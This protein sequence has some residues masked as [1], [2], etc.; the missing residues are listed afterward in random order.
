MLSGGGT[1]SSLMLL[2]A[3]FLILPRVYP[4]PP[5]PLRCLSEDYKSGGGR[6]LVEWDPILPC[7]A[8]CLIPNSTSC[9]PHP[10]PPLD[11][12]QKIISQE[13]VGPC[14]VGPY[15]PLCCSLLNST[16]SSLCCSCLP[17]VYPPPPLRCLSED[18]TCKSGGGRG[19]VEWDLILPS[20]A[21]CFIP[22]P[23]SC[24]TPLPPPPNF[25][26]PFRRL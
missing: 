4:T 1:L 26:M 23:T 2:I 19:L 22:N 25:L 3:S 7:A 11:A 5:P 9:L 21:H 12:F 16:L 14:G 18:H 17:H 10:P 8:H 20:A 13:G 24:P 6:G 15:P